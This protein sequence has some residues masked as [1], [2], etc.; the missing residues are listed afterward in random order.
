MS[1]ANLARLLGRYGYEVTRQSGSHM[2]LSSRSRG[3]THHITVPSH[4]TLRVGTLNRI[5]T[6]VAAYLGLDRDELLR[7]LFGR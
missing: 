4:R 5:V 6:D 1:G 2:R 3:E 7:E